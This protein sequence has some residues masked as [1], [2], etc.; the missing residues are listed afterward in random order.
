MREKKEVLVLL[1]GKSASGKDT[2]CN[3]LCEN[4][5]YNKII[6]Y[7]TRAPRANEEQGNP[8]YFVDKATFYKMNE[9][10][11]MVMSD[12]NGWYYGYKWKD[13]DNTQNPIMVV[14]NVQLIDIVEEA[15]QVPIVIYL[16]R[17]ST[18][19]YITQLERGTPLQ[20]VYR[21]SIHEEGAFQT[22]TK[23][24]LLNIVDNNRPIEEVATDILEIIADVVRN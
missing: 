23:N 12:F 16:D 22:A 21:R 4:Y 2:V 18:D 6:P 13:I 24:P 9:Y 1:I 17:N 8:Y 5:K 19:R 10:R 11:T 3:Y 14:D 7:T 15:L 20:E